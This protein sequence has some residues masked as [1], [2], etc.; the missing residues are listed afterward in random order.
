[1]LLKNTN[2]KTMN[3]KILSS[4]VTIKSTW[5]LLCEI[6]LEFEMTS[7]EMILSNLTLLFRKD[8]FFNL[9]SQKDYYPQPTPNCRYYI[10]PNEGSCGHGIKIVDT[11]PEKI[12]EGYT[13]CP[14]IITP[15]IEK[16]NKKYKYDYRVWI[17]IRSDLTYYICPTFIRRISNIPFSLDSEYGSLTNTALYSDQFDFQD[18]KLYEKINKIV[19]DILTMITPSNRNQVMLTGWDF[20]ENE[21]KDVFVLEVNPNPSINIQHTQVMTEFLSWINMSY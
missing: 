3:D 2:L 9:V 19:Q 16:D 8:T 21:H 17:G 7:W 12:I 11:Y 10:K 6:P 18:A 1:M 4:L 14:E 5:R 20:I 15:L 13:I